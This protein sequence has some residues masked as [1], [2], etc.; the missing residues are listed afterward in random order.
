MMFLGH[1]SLIAFGAWA[2]HPVVG[3]VSQPRDQEGTCQKTTVAILYVSIHSVIGDYP[4]GYTDNAQRGR[5]I[6][7]L[8][9]RKHFGFLTARQ[10]L[11]LTFVANSVESV[12]G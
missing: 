1:L 4:R 7:Y 10:R 2:V 8:G 6:R 12:G 11:P 5:D 9:C 3:Y